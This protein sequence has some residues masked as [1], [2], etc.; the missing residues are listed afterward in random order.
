MAVRWLLLPARRPASS[1]FGPRRRK[2]CLGLTSQAL[3]VVIGC[4]CILE[5][6]KCRLKPLDGKV[7]V[8]GRI[9]PPGFDRIDHLLEFLYLGLGSCEP[10]LG[11]PEASL[12]ERQRGLEVANALLRLQERPG[13]ERRRGLWRS[14]RR[15]WPSTVSIL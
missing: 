4:L 1:Q 13:I 10:P 7:A 5:A 14:S 2:G 11:L 9:F 12:S 6:E 3:G 15:P 8:I